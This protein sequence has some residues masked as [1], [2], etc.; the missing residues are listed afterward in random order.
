VITAVTLLILGCWWI[1]RNTTDTNQ[2]QK[3]NVAPA[4]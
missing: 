4:P 3:I 1:D 2:Q